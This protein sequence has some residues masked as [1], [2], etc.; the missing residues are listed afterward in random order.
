MKV[1]VTGATG[2]VGRNVLTHPLAAAHEV[3][4]PDRR[5]L[6]LRDAGACLAY[7]DREKP[8]LIIHAAGVVGGIQANIDENARF[9]ADNL[10]ICLGVLTAAWKVGV[11]R[12]INLGSS[13]MYPRDV[14]GVLSENMLLGRPLEPTNEGYALAK[15]SAWKLAQLIDRESPG[16]C[17]RT[18]I[19]PNM[20]G[21]YDHFDP[22]RS[23]LMPAIIRKIEDAIVTRQAE[24]EIW[25]DGEARR[26]F[27]FVGDLAEFIWRFHDRLEDLPETLNV[28]VGEDATVNA[29]YYAA[30]AAL[31]FEGSFRHDLSRPVGMRRKLLD[32]SGQGRLGWA[33]GTSLEAGVKIA[34]AYYRQISDPAR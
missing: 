5:A 2:M 9:L 19:P 12:L 3:L 17:F 6:D 31:G 30:A 28:G 18:L 13:C 21:P 25:G 24:V 15:L 20:F 32:V 11:P 1:L 27:L 23:H 22:E 33:P 14:D 10:A 16:Q 8:D 34:A 26:E 4:G 7:I 29:Y